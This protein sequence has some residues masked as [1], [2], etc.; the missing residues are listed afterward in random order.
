MCTIIICVYV[1]ALISTLQSLLI[2]NQTISKIEKTELTILFVEL[3][4]VLVARLQPLHSSHE[5]ID[6]N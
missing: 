4:T 1:V 6:K 5:H 2:F 3:N